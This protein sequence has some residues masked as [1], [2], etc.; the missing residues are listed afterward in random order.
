MQLSLAVPLK[1]SLLTASHSQ[2]T[3]TVP[4]S[5]P[6]PIKNENTKEVLTSKGN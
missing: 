2:D 1:D 4:S 6:G 5:D 3:V